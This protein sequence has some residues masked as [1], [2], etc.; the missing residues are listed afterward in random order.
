MKPCSMSFLSLSGTKRA[1]A[2]Y[3][4][5]AEDKQENSVQIQ[6]DHAKKFAQENDIEI[7]QEEADEGETG[8]TSDREGFKRLFDNFINN[9]NPPHFDFVLV[10]DVT[11]WGRWQNL[12]APAHYE[13]LFEE[14]G[15][16]V[17]YVSRGFPKEGDHLISHL[18]TSIERY[19][20]A[21]YSRQLSNKVF[22]G[23]AKI[24]EQGYSVGGTACYGMA[25][26][27]LDVNKQPIRILKKGEHK[28]I[29]NERVTFAPLNDITTQTV[30]KIFELF[31]QNFHSPEQ[32][33]LI[34]NEKSI[35]AP[36]GG[37]W[38]KYKITR[39]LTNETYTGTRIYNKR[40][41]RLKQK[42][43]KNPRSEWVICPNAF[44]G[45]V[46]LEIFNRAQI[47]LQE[48][49]SVKS[50]DIGYFSRK[51]RKLINTDLIVLV[52]KRDMTDNVS[53][54]LASFPVVFS[55]SYQRNGIPHWC[56]RI[57]EKMKN[58]Q[59]IL[60]IGINRDND[61]SSVVEIF[62]IPTE[63]FDSKN[64]LIFSK[65]HPE[66]S[67]LLVQK[68]EVEKTMV[69]LIEELDLK[70]FFRPEYSKREK[71]DPGSNSLNFRV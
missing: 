16:K 4:H 59:S 45:I 44:P 51:L 8:L 63:R 21:D 27:L 19:M 60:C 17:I 62:D 66:Y 42:S 11:R 23:S 9:P 71:L 31:T 55:L 39:I 29:S 13:F 36:Q 64:Y 35:P 10:Y 33:A 47:R 37:R 22:F 1:I 3:R 69:K 40:W 65:T 6:R 50:K 58:Y 30:I 41:G 54:V 48:Y 57:T 32:V 26:L 14:K 53:A 5:S 34:L 28:Q 52:E 38:N 43:R 49:V 18:Q 12:N 68:R 7:I 70:L 56:F 25:R 67:E 24:S 61:G 15:K 46:S 2:Y 20:A